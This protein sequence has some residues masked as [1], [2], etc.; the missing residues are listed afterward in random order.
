MERMSI[1]SGKEPLFVVVRRQPVRDVFGQCVNHA[2]GCGDRSF[3]PVLRLADLHLVTI[4][5]LDLSTYMDESL[6]RVDVADSHRGGLAEAETSEGRE[7]NE[8]T[9][10]RIRC[11]DQ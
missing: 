4:R 10:V 3:T 8:H 5:P 2:A 11:S 6:G 1:L 7:E 9:E